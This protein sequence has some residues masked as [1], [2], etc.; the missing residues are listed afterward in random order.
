MGGTERE[1]VMGLNRGSFNSRLNRTGTHTRPA[2]GPPRSFSCNVMSQRCN[3]Q[4][5]AVTS[6]LA[7]PDPHAK[8]EYLVDCP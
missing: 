7:E 1:G 5:A 3:K 4:S 2:R 8:R 6:S